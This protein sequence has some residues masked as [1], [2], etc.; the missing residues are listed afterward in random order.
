MTGLVRKNILQVN[1]SLIEN[2]INPKITNNTKY[3]NIMN[4]DISSANYDVDTS[5]I[6]KYVGSNNYKN[7]F[8]QNLN[9]HINI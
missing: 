1:I 8:L 3:T 6:N 4:P 2:I 9:R 7:T 5:S